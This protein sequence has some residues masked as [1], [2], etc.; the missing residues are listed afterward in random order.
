MLKK[1][2][3]KILA[4]GAAAV[5]LCTGMA[6]CGRSANF[7]KTLL[8]VNGEALD[9]G[10]MNYLL[11]Y[12]QAT[13]AR[14][15]S[16]YYYNP[17]HVFDQVVDQETGETYGVS[18]RGQVLEA[19]E[20]LMLAAQKAGELGISLTEE[21]EKKCDEVAAAFFKSNDKKVTN[22]I[23]ADEGDLKRILRMTTLQGKVMEKVG[24][25]ADTEFTDEEVNQTSLSYVSLS[26]TA[27][28]ATDEDGN[29]MDAE[30]I[31][32]ENE[33]K[34]LDMES[35]LASVK[36]QDVDGETPFQ[37]MEFSVDSELF[38]YDTNYRTAADESETGVSQTVMDAVKG[39]ED[40]T[41]VDRVIES[42]DGDRLYVVRLNKAF[43]EDATEQYRERKIKEAKEE[44]YKDKV[45][46]WKEAAEIT[47]DEKLWE[48][49]EVTDSKKYTVSE[50]SSAEESSS[51]ESNG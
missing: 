38:P 32:A 23:G 25:E 26:L 27:E 2:L 22:Q 35:V 19:A 15:Y 16:M 41:L 45:T 13:I 20:S 18:L 24:G 29:K 7:S 30:S 11:R 47:V 10:A 39:L 33:Q 40:H 31:A 43:D 3:T 1:F 9:L 28:D 34:R 21:E 51:E 50:A 5:F 48:T 37:K 17:D 44:Y 49:M 42:E 8:T 4:V 6:G 14:L 12:Q 36:E 46:E